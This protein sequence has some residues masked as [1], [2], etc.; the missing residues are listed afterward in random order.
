MKRSLGSKGFNPATGS[1]P[2]PSVAQKAPIS[3][4]AGDGRM[5]AQTT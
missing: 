4:M 2:F 5:L 1:V 3:V